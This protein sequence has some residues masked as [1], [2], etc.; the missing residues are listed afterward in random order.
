[1]AGSI[2]FTTVVGQ[3]GTGHGKYTTTSGEA[4]VAAVV[5]PDTSQKKV[6]TKTE[7]SIYKRWSRT[8]KMYTASIALI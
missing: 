2:F 7:I 6:Y 5:P 3:I 8:D 4:N 1:M